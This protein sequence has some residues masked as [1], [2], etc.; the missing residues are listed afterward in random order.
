M[1]KSKKILIGISILIGIVLIELLSYKF[2]LVQYNK[3]ESGKG[4]KT[5]E[6]IG[7]VIKVKSN[8]NTT[9]EKTYLGISYSAFNDNFQ[10]AK[11]K[12]NNKNSSYNLY[13]SKDSFTLLAG[14]T[15]GNAT[16]YYDA[17]VTDSSGNIVNKNK[18]LLDTYNIN[19][20]FDIVDYLVNHYKDKVNI[21]SSKSDINI[22]Y[23][24]NSYANGLNEGKIR[25][26][27]GDL[28]GFMITSN[29]G[30]NFEVN[31]VNNEELYHFSFVNGNNATYFTEESVINFLNS[32]SFK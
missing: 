9:N 7:D 29:A 28:E 12:S 13:D 15:V 11:D 32:I 20:N 2:A 10:F 22:H 5:F 14:Y 16:N 3:P 25:Y 8:N 30:T 23:L 6:N 27:E 26:I 19:D 1:K 17:L 31:L 4:Y 21:F 24:M 18:K